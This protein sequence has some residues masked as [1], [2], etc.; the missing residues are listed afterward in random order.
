MESFVNPREEEPSGERLIVNL[1]R[2]VEDSDLSLYQIASLIGTS[3]TILSMWLAG[4]ATPH[5]S[6]LDKIEKF[7][8]AD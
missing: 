7:L 3:G 8:T 5:L 2:F 6:Q 1:R 4:T